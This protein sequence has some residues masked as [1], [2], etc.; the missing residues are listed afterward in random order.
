MVD[1]NKKCALTFSKLTIVVINGISI[2]TYFFILMF[3]SALAE[4]AVHRRGLEQD[5]FDE[6][7]NWTVNDIMKV[8]I[9][10]KVINIAISII[11]IIAVLIERM[12]PVITYLVLITILTIYQTHRLAVGNLN[13]ILDLLPVMTRILLILMVLLFIK[14]VYMKKHNKVQKSKSKTCEPLSSICLS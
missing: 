6:G 9:I 14:E 12:C 13:H 10:G 11:G 3:A 2:I 7:E 4:K 8:I 5:E 1:S